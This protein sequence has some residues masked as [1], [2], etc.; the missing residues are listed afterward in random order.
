MT[1]GIYGQ[2]IMWVLEVL[3][4]LEETHMINDTTKVAFDIDSLPYGR[5]IPRFIVPNDPRVVDKEDL[6]SFVK[7]V[8]V[9]DHKRKRGSYAEFPFEMA[10]FNKAHTIFDRWFRFS[11]EVLSKIPQQITKDTLGIHYRGTDKNIDTAQANPITPEEFISIVEEHL[12]NHPEI[13]SVFCCSDERGFIDA[14]YGS[15]V[16]KS[17]GI[18]MIQYNQPRATENLQQGFFRVGGKV[19]EE[20]RDQLTI[21][22]LVDMLSLS[23]CGTVLKTSSALSSFCK[24]IN[25]SQSVFTVSA[26]KQPWFPA[27]VVLPYRSPTDDPKINGILSRV[28]Q[29]H[30][31]KDVPKQGEYVL[32]LPVINQPLTLNAIWINI[33]KYKD[34]ARFME[35]Q[36]S[37]KGWNNHF[38]VSATT[39]DTVDDTVANEDCDGDGNPIYCCDPSQ[40]FFPDCKNC[41]VERATLTS[42]MKAIQ[43]GLELGDPNGWFIVF[44]D[45]TVI[46]LTLDYKMIIDYAPEDAECLQLFCSNPLTTRK[47]Y[48]VYKR[49]KVL[50]VKWRMILPS[51][52]G[53]LINNTGAKKLLKAYRRD[54]NSANEYKYTFHSSPSCR[55]AD[56][57]IYETLTTYTMTYPMF[58]P[59]IDL[60]SIIHPD[61]L[62][63][64]AMGR[65][66]IKEIIERDPPTLFLSKK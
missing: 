52:S 4:D 56:V 54:G 23:R 65:D 17:A 12:K 66:V 1:E 35:Q 58:Y 47:L 55:L 26:M 29:G 16:I 53:Y 63:S 34:R 33:D 60:G 46:P 39:L 49:D 9:V 5:F 31:Y 48:E 43:K 51:A 24:I 64:H 50:W 14:I 6:T 3:K 25:P 38:R 42:H 37:R 21:A 20:I 18:T 13:T 59:N 11:P 32:E 41:K 19:E 45:D 15:P 62:S 10:S 28:L 2:G 61:H 30:I 40:K 7:T 27:G 8:G 57:M 44:E 22:S 36:F